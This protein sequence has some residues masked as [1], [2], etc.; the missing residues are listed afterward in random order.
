MSG[1]IIISFL[2]FIG[3][4]LYAAKGEIFVKEDEK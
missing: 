2:F 4:V 1:F 3:V